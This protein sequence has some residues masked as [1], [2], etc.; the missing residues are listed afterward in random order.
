M[1]YANCKNIN[2]ALN[3]EVD[4]VKLSMQDDGKGFDTNNTTGKGIGL[5]NMKKRTEMIGG[6]FTIDSKLNI[7]TTLVIT[8]PK[9]K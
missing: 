3:N 2:V 1:K 8:I 5:T 4:F 9:S 6:T 7:G